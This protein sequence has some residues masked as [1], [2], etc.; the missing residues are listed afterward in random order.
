MDDFDHASEIEEQYR[1]L[2]IAAKAL[3]P[4][5]VLADREVIAAYIG[6]AVA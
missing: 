3:D 5:H 6:D 1:A 4:Q 2:A